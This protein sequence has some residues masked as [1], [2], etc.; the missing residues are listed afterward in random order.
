MS[1][2]GGILRRHHKESGKTSICI[3][4][5]TNTFSL[6][7]MQSQVHTSSFSYRAIVQSVHMFSYLYWISGQTME[8]WQLRDLKSA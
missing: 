2:L 1:N 4:L 7:L 3:L 5:N 6:S 8:A